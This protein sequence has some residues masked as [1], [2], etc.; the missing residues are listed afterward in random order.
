MAAHIRIEVEIPE[1]TTIPRP[2]CIFCKE[3]IEEKDPQADS[4]TPRYHQR[5]LD[6]DW[7]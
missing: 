6:R 7:A 5:C 3:E 2:R 1:L 4:T